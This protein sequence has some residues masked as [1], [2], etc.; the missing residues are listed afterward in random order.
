MKTTKL[1]YIG[2]ALLMAGCSAENEPEVGGRTPIKLGYTVLQANETRAATDLNNSHLAA[3]DKVMVKVST[4]DANTYDQSCTYLAIDNT[5]GMVPAGTAIPTYPD[6]N[7]H[8]DIVA[9][10]PS[11]AGTTFTVKA[12]QTSDDNYKAS[13]LMFASISNQAA[14]TET[15]NLTFAHQMAKII[16]NAS[17]ASGSGITISGVTLK[18]IAPTVT[19]TQTAAV[20]YTTN[21]ATGSTDIIMSN[22]GAAL[23]PQQ[24]VDGQFLVISTSAGNATYSLSKEFLAGHQYTLN[25][26]VNSAAV[27]TTSTITG[28]SDTNSSVTIEATV[29]D[30]PDQSPVGA[31]AVDLGLSVKWANMNVGATTETDY[32]TY[33]AWGETIGYTATATFD[34]SNYWWGNSETNLTKYNTDSSRGVV[35]GKTTLDLANDAARINWGGFWRMATKEEFE[36]LI[37]NTSKTWKANYNSSGINGYLFTSTKAGYEDKSIF[38]PAAGYNI[39]NGCGTCGRYWTKTLGSEKTSAAKRLYWNYQEGTNVTF[40]V[41]DNDRRPFV[42]SVRAVQ[43]R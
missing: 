10:Y 7:A 33:F 38:L 34:W 12:D 15:V 41:T 1:L 11:T 26:T 36:E 30:F 23:I 29:S 37:N 20:D 2:V 21:A 6:N 43:D 31:E 9:Y 19:F 3:N 28:W 35:D 42:M 16:V 32:G 4:A 8:V 27:G 14:T 5:G 13:D 25:I 18:N 17:A 22:E 40:A 39:T 24:T